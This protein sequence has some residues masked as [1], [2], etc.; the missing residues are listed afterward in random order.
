MLDFYDLNNCCVYV[1]F[2]FCNISCFPIP[3]FV[4]K[5]IIYLRHFVSCFR[6]TIHLPRK[7]NKYC[8][9]LVVLKV[10]Y[11]LAIIL[12]EEGKWYIFWSEFVTLRSSGVEGLFRIYLNAF[13]SPTFCFVRNSAAV[14]TENGR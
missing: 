10:I 3:L 9:N 5:N 12:G 2:S 8:G 11:N 6:V 1:P 14:L 13:V 4:L 7:S